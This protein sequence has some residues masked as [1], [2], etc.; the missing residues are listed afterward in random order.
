MYDSEKREK[1]LVKEELGVLDRWI[2][3]DMVEEY[4]EFLKHDVEYVT[5]YLQ[6]LFVK[7]ILVSLKELQEADRTVDEAVDMVKEKFNVDFSYRS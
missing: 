3:R 4:T 2:N 6:I 7:D 1:L 5:S